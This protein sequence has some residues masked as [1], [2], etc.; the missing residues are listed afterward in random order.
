MIAS[1][2]TKSVRNV[3]VMLHFLSWIL[4]KYVLIALQLCMSYT[5]S[6]NMLLF[7]LVFN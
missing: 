3:I 6:V 5:N 7:A 2:E 1:R 4:S